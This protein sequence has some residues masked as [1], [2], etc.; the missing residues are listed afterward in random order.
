MQSCHMK[1]SVKAYE[2]DLTED[3]FR[4]L[5]FEQPSLSQ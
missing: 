3:A 2:G 4:D 5:W 1:I